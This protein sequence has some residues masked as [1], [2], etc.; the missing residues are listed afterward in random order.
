M[1]E[2]SQRDRRRYARVERRTPITYEIEGNRQKGIIINF[3]EIGLLIQADE[4]L[5]PGS[6][7]TIPLRLHSNVVHPLH[8]RVKWA[9]L[10]SNTVAGEKIPGNMGVELAAVPVEY[11]WAVADMRKFMETHTPRRPEERYEVYQKVRFKS[12]DTFLTEYTQNLSR[13]GM[14]LATEREFK[15]GTVIRSQLEIPGIPEPLE[16]EGQVSYIL[17]EA[18]A[19]ERGRTRG[20]GVRFINMT[21]EVQSMLH[22]YI[23][24]LAI[25]RATP[26][27]YLA[28]PISTQ[29]S[30]SEYL[31]P[32]ILLFFSGQGKSGCLRLDRKGITKTIY[33]QNGHLVHV[34]SSLRSETLG[35]H[36]TRRGF[37][38]LENMKT[39]FPLVE[40]PDMQ[41]GRAL[42]NEGLIDQ[43][44]LMEALVEYQEE[45]LTNTF[46]WFDG[47]FVFTELAE[48]PAGVPILPL[49]VHRVVC[50]GICHWYDAALVSS[51]MGLSEDCLLRRQEMP[52][53]ESGL[54][55][56]AYQVLNNLWIPQTIK[57]LCT[58][59]KLSIETLLPMAYALIISK[60]LVLEFAPIKE[61]KAE[62]EE[63]GA[64]AEKPPNAEPLEIERW[65]TLI[66]EDYKRLRNLD[67]FEL[68]GVSESASSVEIT[69]AFVERTNRYSS[70]GIDLEKVTDS[71]IL[72]KVSQLLAWIRTAHDTIMD[73]NL[74]NMYLQERVTPED[75]EAHAGSF[76]AEQALLIG[77]SEVQSGN[78]DQAIESLSPFMGKKVF[79]PGVAGWYA[80]ALFKKNSAE[81]AVRSLEILDQAINQDPSDPQLYYFQGEVQCHLERWGDAELAFLQAVRLQS[82]FAEAMKGLRFAREQKSKS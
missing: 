56:L 43:Q 78:P 60:W 9:K 77:I 1:D 47:S 45:R 64:Q 66:E 75:T 32:E 55:A 49:Q 79:H 44:M 24:R 29:G 72:Q 17:D 69:K 10:G 35:Q 12:G 13:G 80:W 74:R 28:T 18:M 5:E 20:V 7:L 52:P 41:L 33:I 34:E 71:E 16:I 38:K 70:Q 8:G 51:W 39:W 76:E 15:K 81:H 57:D 63:K 6:R 67:Y 65:K 73:P 27:R 3:S 26:E 61:E 11:L 62:Q 14:Y 30:L 54:P 50:S 53:G 82:S 25:H 23:Q 42:V 36:L 48:W 21:E 68:L 2:S 46:P 31:V 22:H 58:E 4:V 40:K 19:A 59:H 37:L